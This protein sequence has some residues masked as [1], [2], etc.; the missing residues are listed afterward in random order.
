MHSFR[1]TNPTNGRE[2]HIHHNGDYSGDAILATEHDGV[3]VEIGI[4]CA[5]FVQFA[6]EAARDKIISA[7]EDV[8][9]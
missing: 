2:V 5:A 6:S 1:W 9:L 3:P 4:P 7:I 8:E